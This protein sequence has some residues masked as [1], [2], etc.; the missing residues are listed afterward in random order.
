[1]AKTVNDYPEL[2]D[3]NVWIYIN[4]DFAKADDKF[5]IKE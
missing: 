2:K 1:M 3:L 5:L 4:Y